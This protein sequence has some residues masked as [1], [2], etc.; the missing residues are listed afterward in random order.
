MAGLAL[1]A[2][3]GTDDAAALLGPWET[4][5]AATAV[6]LYKKAVARLRESNPETAI[7]WLARARNLAPDD[8]G[9]L[10]E[11]I[12]HLRLVPE[13]KWPT[14][15]ADVARAWLARHPATPSALEILVLSAAERGELDEALQA[16]DELVR[17]D[18]IRAQAYF[19]RG[20]VRFDR[21]DVLGA[22]ADHST[23]HNLSPA[24]ATYAG[25]VGWDY[26]AL[27]LNDRALAF[28][29]EALERDPGL[30]EA[31]LRR[32]LCR[33]KLG[34]DAGAIADLDLVLAKAENFDARFNRAVLHLRNGR[35]D[36]ARA[37][38]EK[39]LELEPGDART[40]EILERLG[41]R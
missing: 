2:A 24:E 9:V 20:M 14:E 18:P 22:L 29:D 28:L 13:A 33:G 26:Y 19:V 6:R 31:R 12:D 5:D 17:A 32:G 39:A 3:G 21:R 40:K 1:L 8:E 37:D 25:A 38:L 30:T 11:W 36:A 34:D 4:A 27:E 23:A 35:K 41:P 10:G 15:A 7:A 16:A